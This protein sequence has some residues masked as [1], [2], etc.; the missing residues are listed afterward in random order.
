MSNDVV[1]EL[2]PRVSIASGLSEAAAASK[3]RLRVRKNTTYEEVDRAV[4]SIAVV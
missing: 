3:V 2:G 1:D 4:A